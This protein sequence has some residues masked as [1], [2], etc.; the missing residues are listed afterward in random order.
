MTHARA[1]APSP[2]LM[3]CWPYGGRKITQESAVSYP[4]VS[5]NITAKKPDATT[6]RLNPY[7]PSGIVLYHNGIAVYR[8]LIESRESRAMSG[9]RVHVENAHSSS[10]L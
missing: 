1:D 10:S 3:C 6:P 7:V 5:R 8:V 4:V 9:K 2:V